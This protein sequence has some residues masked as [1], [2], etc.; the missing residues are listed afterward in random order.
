MLTMLWAGCFVVLMLLVVLDFAAL[1]KA[2]TGGSKSLA[3]LS[4]FTLACQV[5][6]ALFAAFFI[7]PKVFEGFSPSDAIMYAEL[8]FLALMTAGFLADWRRRGP[9]TED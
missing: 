1:W 6:F 8:A 9:G 4:P 2:R 5:S 7:A 3:W